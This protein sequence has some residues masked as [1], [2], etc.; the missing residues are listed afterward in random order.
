M[1]YCSM[2]FCCSLTCNQIVIQLLSCA[3]SNAVFIA[4]PVLALNFNW[5]CYK[6][7][8]LGDRTYMSTLVSVKDVEFL[9]L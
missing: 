6:I 5:M 3:L 8:R 9:D 7:A 1:F 4:E 2:N